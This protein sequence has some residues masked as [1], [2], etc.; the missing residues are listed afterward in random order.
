MKL[1][2]NCKIEKQESEFYKAQGG[3]LRGDCKECV[4]AKKKAKYKNWTD[5]QKANHFE[6]GK[7][8]N[9]NN[10]DKLKGY[11]S[12]FNNKESTKARMKQYAIDNKESLK[13]YKKNYHLDNRD[14]HLK[15]FAKYRKTAEYKF[16]SRASFHNHRVKDLDG[17]KLTSDELFNKFEKQN[18][19]CYY[20]DI[21]L[22]FDI[23]R[24]VHIDHKIPI[25]K[26]GL[27]VINN[28][29]WCCSN[30]NLKKGVKLAT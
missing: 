27:N 4:S 11:Y 7:V 20:C 10:K 17:N 28:I 3:R 29:V 9:N 8:W 13:E 24:F 22:D 14:K 19:K 12:K 23:P 5:E 1:C 16:I 25:S 6:R 15:S 26:G 2:T 30:C 18:A 21:E